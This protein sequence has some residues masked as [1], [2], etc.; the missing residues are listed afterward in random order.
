MGCADREVVGRN[1]V[2]GPYALAGEAVGNGNGDGLK[3]GKERRYITGKQ[4]ADCCRIP[5]FPSKGPHALV[6]FGAGDT[7]AACRY[8]DLPGPGAAKQQQ[9][10]QREK[11]HGVKVVNRVDD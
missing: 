4:E 2:G 10:G 7:A 8:G 9:R 5:R 1:I 11:F 6:K 3:A